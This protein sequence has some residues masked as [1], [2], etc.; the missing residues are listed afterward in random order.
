MSVSFLTVTQKDV[1]HKLEATMNT[2]RP[3][4]FPTEVHDIVDIP[5]TGEIRIVPLQNG[6]GLYKRRKK[7]VALV[8]VLCLLLVAV[9][10]ITTL[11]GNRRTF[12]SSSGTESPHDN[13]NVQHERLIE[14]LVKNTP[15]TFKSFRD[16]G[17][18]QSRAARFVA[19]PNR[20]AGQQL[21]QQQLLERYALAVLYFATNGASWKNRFHFVQENLET[22]SWNDPIVQGGKGG[23]I[24]NEQGQVVTV[25]LGKFLFYFAK[26]S[27]HRFLITRTA[28]HSHQ[29]VGWNIARRAWSANIGDGSESE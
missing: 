10:L 22:C 12:Q 11:R 29:W 26:R 2:S 6:V 27:I 17:S 28:T 19:S 7:L 16:E 14:Y 15:S 25:H 21:Q 18:P 23:V 5:L 13:T 20:T 4:V 9:V 8:V 24:C 3:I 1:S